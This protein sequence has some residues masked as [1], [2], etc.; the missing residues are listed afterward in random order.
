MQ[1][2]S[3]PTRVFLT[4]NKDPHKKPSASPYAELLTSALRKHVGVDVGSSECTHDKNT[5][6]ISSVYYNMI[7][8]VYV[9]R[10]GDSQAAWAPY[11]VRKTQLLEQVDWDGCFSPCSSSGSQKYSTKLCETYL[12]FKRAVTMT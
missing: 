11:I 6:N 10:S 3:T 7:D 2:M 4:R 8:L 12:Y 5:G 1:K 9:F